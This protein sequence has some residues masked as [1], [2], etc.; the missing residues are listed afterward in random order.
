MD[1]APIEILYYQTSSGKCPFESWLRS[2]DFAVQAVVDARLARVR[3]GLFG[4]HKSLGGGIWEIR[5]NIGPGYRIYYGKYGCEVVILLCA[6][7]KKT[8]AADIDTASGFWQDYLRRT[9]K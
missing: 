8:Q 3:R 7:D 4:D 5:L 6:G 1:V 9:I 2:L